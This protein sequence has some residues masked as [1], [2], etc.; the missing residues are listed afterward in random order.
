MTTPPLSDSEIREN[1]LSGNGLGGIALLSGSTG[2]DIESNDI[3]GNDYW[4][5]VTINAAGANDW[6]G[7]LCLGLSAEN[8]ADAPK[9]PN[10]P[11]IEGHKNPHGGGGD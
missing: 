10:L 6:Q 3:L 5:I 9:C 1:N 4:D 2:N 8:G 11:A 7:N